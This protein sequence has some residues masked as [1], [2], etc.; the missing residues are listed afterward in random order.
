M[1]LC[2]TITK[3]LE[4]CAPMQRREARVNPCIRIVDWGNNFC[5]ATCD[6]LNGSGRGYVQIFFRLYSAEIATHRP[7]TFYVTL[8]VTLGQD[9]GVAGFFKTLIHSIFAHHMD[10]DGVG[11]V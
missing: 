5:M 3:N 1:K 9:D 6:E 7:N 8:Y 10:P 4:P 2:N 11:G